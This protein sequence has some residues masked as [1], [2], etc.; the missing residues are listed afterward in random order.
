[1]VT[2]YNT[3]DTVMIPAII[4]TAVEEDGAIFYEV[5]LDRWRVPE[6]DIQP[7]DW[8]TNSEMLNFIRGLDRV[9]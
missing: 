2:K 1:M 6:T 8:F 4:A 9:R 7:R 3:G 5:E